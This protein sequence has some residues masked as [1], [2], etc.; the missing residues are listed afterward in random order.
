MELRP[1]QYEAALAASDAW[2][3]HDKVLVSSP[4]GT[5]KSVIMAA[6]AKEWQDVLADRFDLPKR[7]LWLAHLDELIWQADEHIKEWTGEPPAIE[8]GEFRARRGA[9][10]AGRAVIV[11]SM[12]TMMQEARRGQFDR[13]AFGLILLDEAHHAPAPG[14]QKVIDYFQGKLLGCTATCDRTDEVPLGKV[15]DTVAF[16]Y[17]LTDA[18]RDGWLAPIRQQYV[19]LDHLDWSR[20]RATQTDLSAE[21]LDAVIMQEEA[22]HSICVPIAECCQGRQTLVFMPSV[23]STR[24]V[25]EVLPRYVRGEVAWIS[26]ATPEEERRV[27]ISRYKSGQTQYLVSCDVLREG[28]DAPATSAIVI[29]RPTQSRL[30]YAQLVGRG[31]RGGPRCPVEGKDDL[32]VLDLVGNSMTH[33]LV[34]CADLLGGQWDSVVTDEANR[35]MQEPGREVPEDVMATLLSAASKSDEL[36]SEQRRQIIAE[37]QLKR[38]TIDPFVIFANLENMPETNLPSWWSNT[39]AD[40]QQCDKLKSLAIPS[41]GLTQNQAQQIINEATRRSRT[42]QASYKQAR[43]LRSRGFDPTMS[44]PE[45]SDVMSYLAD[46]EGGF[47]FVG[48]EDGPR[49]AKAKKR[50]QGIKY[51]ELRFQYTISA[52]VECRARRVGGEFKPH[53]TKSVSQFKAVQKRGDGVTVFRYWEFELE[54]PNSGYNARLL[55]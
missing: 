20:V 49:R 43:Q 46:R 40:A 2:R 14:W 16:H 52:G 24:A 4:T 55:K 12:Q 39:P 15:F 53:V 29:A 3:W 35:I 31:M 44:G 51:S 5:G 13:D 33:K 45:A 21:D 26:G 47:S 54:V 34:T 30:V 28:F 23:T 25:A 41:K 19:R 17:E 6:L 7:V 10:Q 8:K 22:L 42:G 9:K 38:K 1:Y 48:P 37:A 50:G 11:S 18:V 27:I 32:L 36:R